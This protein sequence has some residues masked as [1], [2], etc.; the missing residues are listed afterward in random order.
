MERL[1]CSPTQTAQTLTPWVKSPDMHLSILSSIKTDLTHCL[2]TGAEKERY[3]PHSRQRQQSNHWRHCAEN[4]REQV[5][6][7]IRAKSLAWNVTNICEWADVSLCSLG[8]SLRPGTRRRK[9]KRWPWSRLWSIKMIRWRP[10]RLSRRI[11]QTIQTE[12]IK[13][14]VVEPKLPLDCYKKNP[15]MNKRLSWGCF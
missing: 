15:R 14:F 5:C 11:N 4:H 8:C 12:Q 9:L 3:F 10:K 1:K 6:G 7:I 13:G 2:F